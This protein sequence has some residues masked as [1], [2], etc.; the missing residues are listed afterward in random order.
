MLDPENIPPV[1][2]HELLA[3][4]VTQSSQF[5]SSDLQVKQSLFIP[6]PRRDI[7]VTRHLQATEAE[8]WSAGKDVSQVLGRKLYGRTDIRAD[9][10]KIEP[11]RVVAKPILDDPKIRDNPNHADITGWPEAKEEQKAIALKLAASASKLI[12]PS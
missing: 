7:S 12:P 6:H 11:L 8:I 2:D 5:R 1:E 9:A 10:C 3:R 4:Y